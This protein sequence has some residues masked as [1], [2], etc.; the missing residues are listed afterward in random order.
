MHQMMIRYLS[1]QSASTYLSFLQLASSEFKA[2]HRPDKQL[3][4]VMTDASGNIPDAKTDPLVVAHPSVPSQMFQYHFLLDYSSSNSHTT[5]MRDV[6]PI[7]GNRSL[8]GW[9]WRS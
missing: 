2:S 9:E 3:N 6:F 7:S 5:V 8:L 4:G 1:M